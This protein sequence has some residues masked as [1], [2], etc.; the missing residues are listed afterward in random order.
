M[1]C[2]VGKIDKIIRVILGLV[3]VW[4]SWIYSPLLYIIAGSLFITAAT[5]HCL[6]NKT[7]GI[8]TCKLK[9]ER[10]YRAQPL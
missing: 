7:L 2:N 1:T 5:G 9:K 6:I 8:N 3:F 10:D 4:L